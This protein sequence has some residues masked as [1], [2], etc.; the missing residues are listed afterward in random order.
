MAYSF[1]NANAASTR[2]TQYFEVGGHRAIYYEGW[3]AAARHG[4]PWVLSGSTPFDRDRWELFNIDQDF[5]Q[6]ND[7]AAANPE[8]LKES[9]P[10]SIKK[11]RGMAS[12]A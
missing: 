7:V 4:V 10:Y 11:R 12:T 6:A 9:R 1:E 3:I 8:K 2:A 5:S